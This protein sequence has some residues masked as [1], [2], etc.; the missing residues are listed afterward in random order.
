MKNIYRERTFTLLVQM[1]ANTAAFLMDHN[2][3]LAN[4]L[5]IENLM[6]KFPYTVAMRDKINERNIALKEKTITVFKKNNGKL[7]TF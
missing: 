2:T 6:C 5:W 1:R 4:V 7:S 3:Q